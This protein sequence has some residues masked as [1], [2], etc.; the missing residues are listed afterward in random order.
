MK[1]L[2]IF[3]LF[4]AVAFAETSGTINFTYYNSTT[5]LY[6]Y[7]VGLCNTTSVCSNY[8]CFLDY[9]GELGSG[10][11]TSSGWCNATAV[12]SCYHDGASYAAGT[13]SC[14]SGSNTT[15]HT[16]GSLGVWSNVTTCSSGACVG[17]TTACSTPSSS[18]SSSGSASNITVNLVP[19]IIF[20]SFPSDFEIVQ[21]KTLAKT[22]TVKNNGNQT[23]Y[24]VTLSVAGVNWYTVVPAK[25]SSLSRNGE[26]IF[27][28][29][30][31]APENAD[32]KTYAITFVLNSH[33]TSRTKDMNIVVKPSEQTANTVIIPDYAKY[34]T[35]LDELRSNMSALEQAG[36]DVEEI[37]NLLLNAESKLKQVK[38]SI[39]TKDYSTAIEYTDDARGLLNAAAAKLAA[40]VPPSF[41]IDP[42]ILAVIIAAICVAAVIVY[43]VIPP[44]NTTKRFAEYFGRR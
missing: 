14:R 26:A 1:K 6:G 8:K 40:T 7:T 30:F 18:S 24:N 20:S 41:H 34:V 33:N 12:T 35:L 37:S 17:G 27:N 38:I 11:G 10:S 39:D 43:L 32:T 44:K 3:L 13:Y 23:L 25:F 16:C 15:Y 22:T 2:L 31:S 21:G 36:A 29:T 19:S 9:D 28:L 42:I 4:A 5:G